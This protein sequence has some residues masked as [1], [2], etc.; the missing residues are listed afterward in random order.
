MDGGVDAGIP[1][2][3]QD[4]ALIQIK[5]RAKS[6]STSVGQKRVTIFD[7]WQFANILVLVF[8]GDKFWHIVVSN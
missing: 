7:A 3:N 4:Q 2:A 5:S 1:L 6:E 8:D